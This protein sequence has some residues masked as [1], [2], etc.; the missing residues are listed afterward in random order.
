[1]TIYGAGN[2]ARDYFDARDLARLMVSLAVGDIVADGVFNIGSGRGMT[3]ADVVDAV[4]EVLGLDVGVDHQP[5]RPFDL[6][7]SVLDISLAK[8]KLGWEPTF[9]FQDTVRDLA[10]HVRTDL[11]QSAS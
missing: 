7:Y 2:N 6:P 8:K 9:Q 4:R 10:E 1:V 11:L 5:T 3:E